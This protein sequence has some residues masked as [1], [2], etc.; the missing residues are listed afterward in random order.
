MTNR[1]LPIGAHTQG[2]S[3]ASFH[4]W[5]PSRKRVQVVL[6]S[7]P[8]APAEIDLI[9]EDGYFSG[10]AV[11]AAAGTRYRYRLD[12]SA[13]L[14]PDPASRFQPDGPHGPSEIVDPYG[15]AWTDSGWKGVTLE[16]QV[17]YELH[18]GTFTDEGTWDAARRHLPELAET[19]ITLVEV[20]PVADF[21]GRFGW[22]YDGVDLFA[23]TWL[24]GQPDDLRRFVDEA[25]A[26]GI[27]VILDV[28]YNHVGPDGNYLAEFSPDYFTEGLQERL[29]RS[30]QLRWPEG[31]PG[32]R[33]LH[34][35]CGVLDRRISP[36]R[37]AARRDAADFRYFARTHP[38]RHCKRAR[39]GGGR[40]RS[41]AGCRE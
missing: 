12:D 18:V 31:R 14:L 6:E 19:G 24:Y 22:G 5:A 9:E 1:L 17:I 32:A 20:M 36:G 29:G 35:E 33:I 8:G 11:Q 10:T 34:R 30:H 3:G 2:A 21:P 15:F 28:V 39:A 38:R 40:A 13:T 16:G 23:P 37:L 41:Y 4:V 25:H 26:L 7:G 27:G